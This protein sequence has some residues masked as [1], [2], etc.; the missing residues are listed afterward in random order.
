MPSDIHKDK[1]G[2]MAMII[3]SR[4]GRR[5]SCETCGR[6]ATVLC[7]Y[8]VIRNGKAATCDR[9][10]CRPHAFTV[11]ENLDYCMPHYNA[12]PPKL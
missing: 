7:D 1:D 6:P 8:P 10:C 3:C 2:N 4:G 12:G 11:G 9:W 5:H